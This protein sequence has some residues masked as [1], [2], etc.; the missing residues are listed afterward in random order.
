MGEGT[1]IKRVE[2]WEVGDH[3]RDLQNG[4]SANGV[5]EQHGSLVRAMVWT[6]RHNATKEDLAAMMKKIMEMVAANTIDT[7]PLPWRARLLS[8]WFNR[9][10]YA[11]VGLASIGA[12]LYGKSKGWL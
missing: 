2:E 8:E 3:I 9:A 7:K 1:Q 10:P 4:Q 11:V 6:I 12:W 5:C